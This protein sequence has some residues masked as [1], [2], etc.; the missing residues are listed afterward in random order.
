M[1]PLS[2]LPWLCQTLYQGTGFPTFCPGLQLPPWL[3]GGLFLLAGHRA[4]WTSGKLAGGQE[5]AAPAAAAGWTPPWAP[6]CPG[7]AP[8]SPEG[9]M[10]RVPVRAGAQRVN[11]QER[12]RRQGAVPPPPF[13][14]NWLNWQWDG[15]LTYLTCRPQCQ[16]DGHVAR[17]GWESLPWERGVTWRCKPGKDRTL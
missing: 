11:T 10:P 7:P 2:S 4:Q 5:R 17:M 3:R 6:A 13:T 16:D 9:A 12:C 8:P 14:P 15:H 1:L